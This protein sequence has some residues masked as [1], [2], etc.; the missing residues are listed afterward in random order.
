MAQATPTAPDFKHIVRIANTDLDGKKTILYGLCRIKGVGVMFANAVCITG[1]IDGKRKLGS[2]TDGEMQKIDTII[3][4]PAAHKIPGWLCNRRRDIETGKDLHAVGAN[5]Q[6]LEENDV[7]MMKKIK[8]YKGIRHMQGAPVRGQRT[9]SNFRK[10]KGS[11]M[12]VKHPTKGGGG[13]T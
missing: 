13:T 6:F 4:D 1:K 7:K 11:V 10:N 5:L 12:G 9:R 3:K 8:S 2:L